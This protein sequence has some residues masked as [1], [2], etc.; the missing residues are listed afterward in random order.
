MIEILVGGVTLGAVYALIALGMSLVHAISRVV[1]LAQGGFVVLAALAAAALQGRW[2]LPLALD[3][4]LVLAAMTAL[5]AVLELTVVRPA[6][7]R[8]TPDRLLLVTVGLLQATGGLLLVAWGNQPYTMPPFTGTRPLALD[9]V[10]VPT[11]TLWVVGALLLAVLGLWL[12]LYRTG[13]GLLLRAAAE[14]PAAARLSGVDADRV[15]TLAFAL[16]GL[17]AGLAG[18]TVIPVTFA[19]FDTTVPYA[20]NGFIAAVLGGLGRLR[21]AVAGGLLLGVLEAVFGRFTSGTLAEVVAIAVLVLLLLLRP[22]GLFGFA[23]G[24]R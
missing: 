8:A 17:M 12:L 2:H 3:L 18:V 9:G 21:G 16:S 11:Q 14:N 13:I 4:V 10:L 23:E 24:R 5:L 20:V 19:A 1:N 22:A 15:R 6:V 7:R